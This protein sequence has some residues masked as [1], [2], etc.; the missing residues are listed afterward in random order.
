MNG[1]GG[2][3]GIWNDREESIAQVY[4][5]WYV[6]EH[7][8]ERLAIPGFLRAHRYENCTGASPRFFTFYELTGVDVLS[9][10]AYLA[11]LDAPSALTREVMAHFR[12]MLRSA[13]VPLRRSAQAASGGCV[14]VSWACQPATIDEA[15]LEAAFAECER[16]RGVVAVQSWRAAPDAGAVSVESKLRPGAD[17]KAQ[18]VLVAGV[19]REA[20]GVALAPV[21]DRMLKAAVAEPAQPDVT[22]GVFRLLASWDAA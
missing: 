1:A 16:R 10:R 17:R 11:R 22:T 21:L 13:F 15:S 4:E 14:V 12:N 9:S 6:S 19:M 2:I 20:D 3:L 18:A 5:Q 8:P 7:V